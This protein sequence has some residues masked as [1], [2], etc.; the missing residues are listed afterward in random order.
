MS[1]E[2]MI[3]LITMASIIVIA[4]V[5]YFGKITKEAAK[6][7]IEDMFSNKDLEVR[8]EIKLIKNITIKLY[9]LKLDSETKELDRDNLSYL[10]IA[11]IVNKHVKFKTNDEEI[12]VITP[13]FSSDEFRIEFTEMLEAITNFRLSQF[14]FKMGNDKTNLLNIGNDKMDKMIEHTEDIITEVF[15]DLCEIKYVKQLEEIVM[16]NLLGE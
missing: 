1:K 8:E 9:E 2:L 15:D 6:E 5:Y 13:D 7:V 16:N 11:Q 4:I 10:K 12:S 3:I 14:R